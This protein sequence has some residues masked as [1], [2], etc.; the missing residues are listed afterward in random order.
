[1]PKKSKATIDKF[2]TPSTNAKKPKSETINN[3][4]SEKDLMKEVSEQRNKFCKSIMEFKFNKKRTKVLTLP[5]IEEVKEKSNGI[6]YWM[7]RDQRIQDNWALLYAQRTAIKYEVP[8]YICFCI[9]PKFLDATIRQ[10]R[11]MLRGLEEVAEEAKQLNISFHLLEGR[12]VDVLPEFVE[13]RNIG[14]VITDFSPVRII[15]QWT[16]ELS[17]RMAAK[18]VAVCQIDGHNVVP[19]WVASEKCEYGARTIRP[20]IHRHLTEFLTEFPPVISHPFSVPEE[21]ESKQIDWKQVEDNLEVNREVGDCQWITAGTSAAFQMLQD[22]IDNRLK[23]FGG[24]RNDPNIDCLSNLSPY[25]HFGQIS[26][27]RVILEV[28]KSKSKLKESVDAFVEETVVRRELA[29]NYCYYN[30]NYD[31]IEGAH[32]WAKKT[33]NDHKKDKRDYLYSLEQ[34]ETARTHDQLWNAAQR[35]MTRDGKMHGF[36]RMYWAKKILEWTK[37]PEEALRIAIHLND[38]YELDGRDPNGYVGCMWSICGLHDQGWAERKV[39]GKI[40][41]MNDK[42]CQRKFDVNEYINKYRK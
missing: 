1:M 19:V 6:V 22:F 3:K 8:L 14:A 15:K 35:Q 7:S 30:D 38:K 42:G 37:S 26:P 31:N 40:R 23:H 29:D 32:D 5:D 16:E 17:A 24:K 2:F 11:F 21:F 36:M 9:V 41:Y 28:N 33:L 18:G 39:F 27:Q 25:F 10:F 12:V 4:R 34:L 20:K 13:R